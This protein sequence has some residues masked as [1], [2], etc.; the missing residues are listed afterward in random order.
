MARTKE[1][2]KADLVWRYVEHLREMQDTGQCVRLTRAEL[3]ELVEV[4][5]TASSVSP[6]VSSEPCD[7]RRTNVRTRME[8]LLAG[9]GSE[10]SRAVPVEGR[11]TGQTGLWN[12]V[13][14]LEPWKFQIALAVAAG[15]ALALITVNV[16]HQPPPVTRVV[17]VRVPVDAPDVQPIDEQQAHELLPRMVHNQLTP[18]EE[19]NLMWHMLVCPGCFDDYVELKH[20]VASLQFPIPTAQRAPEFPMPE[21]TDLELASLER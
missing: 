21:D 17:R 10:S 5:E 15:L 12:T 8:P 1:E 19:K 20:Q 2:M 3:E 11:G 4:L 7:A 13:R 6:V 16:W 14:L 9:P 18:Q